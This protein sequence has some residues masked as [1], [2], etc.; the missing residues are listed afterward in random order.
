MQGSTYALTYVTIVAY[1]NNISSSGTSATMQ[2]IG[3]G[4]FDI[5]GKFFS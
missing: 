2:A 3:T 5:T 4:V 1:S